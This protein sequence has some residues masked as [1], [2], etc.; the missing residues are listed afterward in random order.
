MALLFDDAATEYLTMSGAAITAVPLTMACWFKSDSIALT[1]TL[2]SIGNNG[3]R[4]VYSLRA[5][6]NV[7]SDPIEAIAQDDV[8][9][10]RAASSAGYRANVWHHAAAVFRATNSRA[11]YLDGG[12]KGTNTT[13]ITNPTGDFTTLAAQQRNVVEQYL[14]GYLAEAAMWSVALS[15]AEI[16]TLAQGFS[17]LF[18]QPQS[19]VA[20]W[21]LVRLN[22]GGIQRDLIEGNDLTETNTPASADHPQ[23]IFYPMVAER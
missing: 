23:K 8:G 14:S 9:T 3:A 19:L 22:A 13:S 20:Y 17:P 2:M 21:P 18:I 15:D 16:A 10:A 7:A 5:A 6:G 12:N 11:A 1:Q 4:G